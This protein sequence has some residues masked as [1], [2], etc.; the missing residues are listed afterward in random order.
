MDLYSAINQMQTSDSDSNN[1]SSSEEQDE[2]Q[3]DE[4][5][6]RRRKDEC[7]NEIID[8]ERQFELIRNQLYK[9]RINQAD[10]KLEEVKAETAEDYL[11]PLEELKDNMRIRTEVAGIL[12]ELRLKNVQCQHEAEKRAAKQNFEV[13]PL[14]LPDRARRLHDLIVYFSF[15][16]H[17]DD[18]KDA[19]AH[20]KGTVQTGAGG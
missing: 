3:L 12:R 14:L 18:R 16:H 1:D 17:L 13:F 6:Y 2:E 4:E 15:P 11:Q 7:T 9:E 19:K 8:L 10:K 5:E 20:A